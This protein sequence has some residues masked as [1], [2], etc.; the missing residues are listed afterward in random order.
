ML[1]PEEE[2]ILFCDATSSVDRFGTKIFQILTNS[3]CGGLPIAVLLTSAENEASF[4]ECLRMFQEF[5]EDKAFGGRGR[6]V[7]KIIMTD[8]DKVEQNGFAK[9]FSKTEQ[10]LCSFHILQ[11]CWRYLCSYKSRVS[12]NY[13]EIF[14]FYEEI[15]ICRN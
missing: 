11:C 15:T 8:G 4:I 9:V 13:Q 6:Q 12:L 2:E 1:I 5:I 3:C 14:F 7:P 10:L